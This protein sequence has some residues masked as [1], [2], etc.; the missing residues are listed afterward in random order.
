MKRI[1]SKMTFFYKR[2][3][4]VLWFGAL[5]AAFISPLSSGAFATDPMIIVILCVVVVVGLVAMRRFIWRLAD[6]VFDNGQSLLVRYRGYE[7]HVAL[8][9]IM[10]V[11]VSS[12]TRPP[13]VT[14]RLIAPAHF[15]SEVAFV[16]KSRFTL[17][18]FAKNAVGEELISRVYQARLKHAP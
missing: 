11:S 2:V 8:S 12:L 15:G 18:P 1:S 17:N 7:E 4:P 5:A 13:R 3:F 9:N 14:L 6:E 16:P 10:N